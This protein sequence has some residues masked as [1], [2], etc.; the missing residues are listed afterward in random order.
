MM[1]TLINNYF[2]NRRALIRADFNVP[3]DENLSLSQ[4][5]KIGDFTNIYSANYLDNKLLLGSSDYSTP[6]TVYV[7]NNSYELI[8]TLEVNVLPGDF[9]VYDN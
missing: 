3:L 2:S 7:Y 9:Q 4:T 5:G 1:R 6:E 8:E